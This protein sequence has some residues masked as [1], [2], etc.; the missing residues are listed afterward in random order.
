MCK[1]FL[2]FLCLWFICAGIA[3]KA[4]EG[5]AIALLNQKNE[6]G[7]YWWRQ[8]LLNACEASY[9]ALPDDKEEIGMPLGKLSAIMNKG[10]QPYWDTVV[11]F[12]IA[13]GNEKGVPW[14]L[15]KNHCGIVAYKNGQFVVA[16]KGTDFSSITNPSVFTD[17]EFDRKG[18]K[19]YFPESPET[20]DMRKFWEPTKGEPRLHRGFMKAALSCRRDVLAI[21]AKLAYKPHQNVLVLTGHSLGGAIATLFAAQLYEHYFPGQRKVP[22]Y[23]VKVVTFGAPRPFNRFAKTEFDEHMGVRALARFVNIYKAKVSWDVDDIVT[24]LP[25]SWTNAPL[26]EQSFKNP[27]TRILVTYPRWIAWRVGLHYL[28]R[29]RESLSAHNRDIEGDDGGGDAAASRV[30]LQ[31]M[32]ALRGSDMV[33]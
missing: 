3:V 17:L 22:G 16:F 12:G 20:L 9:A 15:K 5:D 6:Q 14:D 32:I 30:P 24:N 13:V 7:F 31:V 2:R 26:G 19:N 23:P 1:Y 29:Y 21:L 4:C 27:G 33:R 28:D 10:F 11:P 18:I 25:P 8:T